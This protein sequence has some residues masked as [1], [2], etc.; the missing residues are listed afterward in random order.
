MGL[1][2]RAGRCLDEPLDILAHQRDEVY[3]GLGIQSEPSNDASLERVLC[4]DY[5]CDWCELPDPLHNDHEFWHGR[6]E[7][8]A[9]T[10]PNPIHIPS[11]PAVLSAPPT[12]TIVLRA[13]GNGEPSTLCV[14]AKPY[15]DATGITGNLL[16]LD[17]DVGATSQVPFDPSDPWSGPIATLSWVADGATAMELDLIRCENWDTVSVEFNASYC[18]TEDTFIVSAS[19]ASMSATCRWLG[20]TGSERELILPFGSEV[21]D[22]A[23]ALA[24]VLDVIARQERGD[25]DVLGLNDE[26]LSIYPSRARSLD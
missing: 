15:G 16:F 12:Q 10:M 5:Q 9:L 8:P 17:W 19:R 4:I 1:F 11:S 13:T 23:S 14:V 26:G 18:G 3:T 7:S 6:G 24:L 25:P 21:L 22:C 2:A 20:R